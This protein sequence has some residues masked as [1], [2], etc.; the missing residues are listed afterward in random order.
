V[1]HR[2]DEGD[3]GIMVG[4]NTRWLAGAIIANVFFA[5]SL[6]RADADEIVVLHDGS[7]FRGTLVEL[8]A[9]DH[10]TIKLATG[11]VRR[12]AWADV[13]KTEEVTTTPPPQQP[14]TPQ[15]VF[16]ELAAPPG[17]LLQHRTG[18]VAAHGRMGEAAIWSDACTA[19]CQMEVPGGVYRVGGPSFRGTSEINLPTS[20]RV[21]VD[22]QLG[23][24]SATL[25]GSL[26][27]IFGGALLGVG[28]IYGVLGTVFAT[29]GT[30]PASKDL[31]VTFAAV[32]G[33]SGAVGLV[34]LI[35]GVIVV[36]N[37]SSHAAVVQL[38]RATTTGLR[39]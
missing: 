37:N 38:A 18:T 21:R 39:F 11:E 33:I 15:G 22:A 4:P 8:V 16:V 35:P 34:L 9:N 2:R 23:S 10:V 13:E 5:A 3:D 32:G 25:G 27:A 29:T 17:A 12:F 7:R 30:T 20:G 31:G 28:V 26:L 24:A 1:D 14:V 6:A 36:S 19:P